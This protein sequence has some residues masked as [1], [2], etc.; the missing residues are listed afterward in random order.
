MPLAALSHRPESVAPTT[1]LAYVPEHPLLQHAR[2]QANAQTLRYSGNITPAVAWELIEQQ[3]AVLVD[4]RTAE[5]RKFVGYVPDSLHLPWLIGTAM[6]TNPRFLRELEAKVPKN[7][8]VL[9][10]CRSGTRSVAAATAAVRAGFQHVYNIL[11]GFE[12]ELD[13]DGHRGT[14]NGWRFHGLR[15]VQD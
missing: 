10:L 4:V 13:E 15:W 3:A 7:A 8:V 11:E 6:Q 14:G 12:G 5:E 1:A 9:L 2:E